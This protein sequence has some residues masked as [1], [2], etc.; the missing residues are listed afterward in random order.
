MAITGKIT[1]EIKIKVDKISELKGILDEIKEIK[2][3]HSEIME[4]N[5]EV[6]L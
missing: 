5:I 4:V 2:R 1:M 6:V 3:E